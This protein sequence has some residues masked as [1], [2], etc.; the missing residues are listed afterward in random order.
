MVPSYYQ[1]L[2]P[3]ATPLVLPA[4]HIALTGVVWSFINTDRLFVYPAR[5][6]PDKA[7]TKCVVWVGGFRVFRMALSTVLFYLRQRLQRGGGGTREILQ[8][9]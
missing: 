3:Y 2:E 9:L 4:T 7:R 8:H 5:I 1:D 6:D